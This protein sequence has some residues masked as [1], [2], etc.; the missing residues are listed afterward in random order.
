MP[1][2]AT[3]I[4]H[5]LN[6][7]PCGCKRRLVLA[8]RDVETGK[9]FI[10]WKIFV[11]FWVFCSWHIWREFTP[12]VRGNIPW[13]ITFVV[14]LLR[15]LVCLLFHSE[16][17]LFHH[18]LT[19]RAWKDLLFVFGSISVKVLSVDNSDLQSREI[20]KVHPSNSSSKF[21]RWSSETRLSAWA[22]LS[23]LGFVGSVCG[24]VTY[25]IC[26]P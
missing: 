2:K 26:D 13:D 8:V 14:Q 9:R 3:I 23:L 25:L 5:K 22:N 24:L 17:L 11:C 7:V 6:S 19:H 10:S 16:I 20:H 18:V 12:F 21:Q 1:K 15:Q 4:L